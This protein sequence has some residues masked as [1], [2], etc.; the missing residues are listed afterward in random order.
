MRSRT[1]FAMAAAL[2]VA[3]FPLAASAQVGFAVGGGPSTP[4]GE[5]ADE[6]GTGFHVQGSVTVGLPLLPV[7]FRGDLLFQQF[8]DEHSG[9]FRQVGGLA[10]ATVGLPLPLPV[11]RPYAIGG[12][13]MM[14]ETAPEEDHGD[15]A[16]EGE[17]GFHPAFNVGAGVRLGLPGISAFL[18]ARFLDVGGH[19]SLPVTVGI[20]F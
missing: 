8:P 14:H 9:S 20:R 16:H 17:S 7:G 10:N 3:A 4:L 2:A 15:H 19:R 18:E 13:G 1:T 5:L 11:L 12:I 6:A